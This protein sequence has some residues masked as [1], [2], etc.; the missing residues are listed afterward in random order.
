MEKTVFSADAGRIV[1]RRFNEPKIC[2]LFTGGGKGCSALN[3]YMRIRYYRFH[4]GFDVFVSQVHTHKNKPQQYF[5]DLCISF[6]IYL[7][8]RVVFA[9]SHSE[10]HREQQIQC[11]VIQ[12]QISFL[13]KA[14]GEK[15]RKV[16]T[17]T[18]FKELVFVE[19]RIDI[20]SV[21]LLLP[22]QQ[23]VYLH[24]SRTSNL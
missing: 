1:S 6:Y 23:L 2:F 14:N 5:I 8:L 24:K 21:W 12:I 15:K 10:S 22:N 20:D 16:S 4:F 19:E 11:V 9:Y 3:F 13:L 7:F 17:H 18:A